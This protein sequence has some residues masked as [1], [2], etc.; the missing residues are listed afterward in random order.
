MLAK[1]EREQHQEGHQNKEG[2]KT[3]LYLSF[4]NTQLY[5][6]HKSQLQEHNSRTR[7]ETLTMLRYPHIPT[8]HLNLPLPL[9]TLK[10][11]SLPLLSLLNPV[12]PILSSSSSRLNPISSYTSPRLPVLPSSAPRLPSPAQGYPPHPSQPKTILLPPSSRH[13]TPSSHHLVISEY[14]VHNYQD[15]TYNH[16]DLTVNHPVMGY[17]PG[18]ARLLQHRSH[19]AQTTKVHIVQRAMKKAHI[20]QRA[21]IMKKAHI[22]PQKSLRRYYVYL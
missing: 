16:Q 6:L 1:Q 2:T 5:T 9:Q 13:D 12:L 18:L 4:E 11:P 14:Q 22:K 8:A 3:L 10:L 21:Y 7:F 17:R 15:L 20:M 19:Q